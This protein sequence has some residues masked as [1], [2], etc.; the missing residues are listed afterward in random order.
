MKFTANLNGTILCPYQILLDISEQIPQS[1]TSLKNLAFIPICDLNS[2]NDWINLES[3]GKP[4]ALRA[5]AICDIVSILLK[6]QNIDKLSL[7]IHLDNGSLASDNLFCLLYLAQSVSSLE[8]TFFTS[9]ENQSCLESSTASLKSYDNSS[10]YFQTEPNQSELCSKENTLTLLKNSRNQT[11]KNLGFDFSDD[12]L[13]KEQI[14]EFVL[15]QLIGFAWICL[16]SGGYAI[17]CQLLEKATTNANISNTMQEQLFMHLLMIRFFS[18]QYKL[19]TESAFPKQFLSLEQSEVQTLQFLKAYSATLSRNLNVAQE[20]FNRCNI[21]EQMPLNDENSLY[22]LNLFALSKVLQGETDTAFKLEFRIESFI[23]EHQIDTVGL[24]YV[25]FINIARLYKKIKQYDLSL[26][27]YNKAYNEISGGGYTTSDHIYYNMNLGSLYEAAGN[28]EQALLHWINTALHWLACKNKFELSWRPRLILCQE[29]LSDVSKPLPVDNANAFLLNK[30]KELIELCGIKLTGKALQNHQFTND[31]S[32]IT[33]E[34]C[35]IN[36]NILFYTGQV[37]LN[38]CSQKIS[39]AEQN[40]SSLVSEFLHTLID[41]P[42]HQNVFIVDTQLDIVPLASKEEA[43]AFANL[44]NCSSC[45]FNGQWLKLD[46]FE[47]IK[48]MSFSLSKVIQSITEKEHGL[49]VQYKRS[50]LNKTLLNQGEIDLV[51]QLK[52]TDKLSLKDITDS[53]WEIVHQLAKKR[54]LNFSYPV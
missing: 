19:I 47:L 45:Y 6:K 2:T 25:N 9:I 30:I 16:K 29:T 54:I 26:E 7:D 38:S 42:E 36:K 28:N 1:P 8:I 48:P 17:A 21:N 41:I 12:F 44:S 40:L 15:K 50:F 11:I 32:S 52:L 53:D 20:F 18:H 46:G 39:A 24:K 31:L 23:K 35:F 4:V 13:N 43:M 5:K 33:K 49:S 37:E 3:L 10:I 27:Y 34:L 51:Q 14:P 22:Q